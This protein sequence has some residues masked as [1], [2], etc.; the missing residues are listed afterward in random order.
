L[1]RSLATRSTVVDELRRPIA[2]EQR[3]RRNPG[4]PLTYGLMELPATSRRSERL[5]G[6]V[7]ALSSLTASRSLA[8]R[9]AKP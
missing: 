5:L 3:Q 1:T 8:A 7:Q 9:A 4:E 2:A 6:P